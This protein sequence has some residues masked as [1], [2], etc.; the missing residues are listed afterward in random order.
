MSIE[1]EHSDSPPKHNYSI[2]K[3]KCIVEEFHEASKEGRTRSPRWWKPHPGHRW[4]DDLGMMMGT[5]RQGSS[6]A[7]AGG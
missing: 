4:S 7:S 2:R 6:D 3:V 1:V 5:G